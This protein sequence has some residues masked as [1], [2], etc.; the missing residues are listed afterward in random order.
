MNFVSKKVL[1]MKVLLILFV[2]EGALLLARL[3]QDE[4]RLQIARKQIKT[5]LIKV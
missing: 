1:R 3:Y 5:R 2:L 4:G